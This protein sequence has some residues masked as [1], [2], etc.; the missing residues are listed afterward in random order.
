MKRGGAP[1]GVVVVT[2]GP[3]PK[4]KH[5]PPT[6]DP[7]NVLGIS[8]KLCPLKSQLPPEESPRLAHANQVVEWG[9]VESMT[10]SLSEKWP[11]DEGS[12]SDERG[13]AWC[14]ARSA[15]LN[16]EVIPHE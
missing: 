8:A 15:T 16:I 11:V 12:P 14:D 10:N 1:I 13:G 9:G 2:P 5:H 6:G 7:T 4:S 3:P